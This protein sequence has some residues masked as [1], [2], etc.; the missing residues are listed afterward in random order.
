[1][2]DS[3]HTNFDEIAWSVLNVENLLVQPVVSAGRS[4]FKAAVVG[5]CLNGPMWPAAPMMTTAPTTA[6]ATA[7]RMGTFRLL[8]GGAA[9]AAGG[10]AA[11]HGGVGTSVGS[12]VCAWSGRRTSPATTG[13]TGVIGDG[14]AGVAVTTGAS[15]ATGASDTEYP[16]ARAN[17]PVTHRQPAAS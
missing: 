13:T 7:I 1:M 2:G 4:F 8:L 12:T 17:S 16:R 15:V 6:M 9:P 3:L 11:S 5:P 14:P 10:A